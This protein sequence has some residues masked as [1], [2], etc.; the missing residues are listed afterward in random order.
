V[1]APVVNSRVASA[2]EAHHWITVSSESVRLF[3]R[4]AVA[5]ADMVR[6]VERHAQNGSLHRWVLRA[7]EDPALVAPLQTANAQC[8]YVVMETFKPAQDPAGPPDGIMRRWLGAIERLGPALNAPVAQTLQYNNV[9]TSKLHDAKFDVDS[10]VVI[11]ESVNAARPSAV[12]DLQKVLESNAEASVA[13]GDCLEFCVLEALDAPGF[14]KT[15]EVYANIDLLRKHVG[16]L[17]SVFLENAAPFIARSSHRSR[18]AFR[19]V[20]FS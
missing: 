20:V 4:A 13:C 5:H 6:R 18:S 8:R 16:G 11:V 10:A 12:A 3:E 7:V 15:I 9:F 17:D 1:R 14:F 2:V 19:P